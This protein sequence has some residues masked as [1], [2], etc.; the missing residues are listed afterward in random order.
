MKLSVIT[1]TIRKEGLEIVRKSLAKQT[2]RDF[3]W[4]VCAPFDPEIP[5]ARFIVDNFGDGYWTL[6]RCYNKLFRASKGEL[7]VSYQD[8]IWT[9][10]DALEKFWEMYKETGGSITSVGD[11]YDQ[12]DEYGRPTNA[13]WFD[14][15][16]R[17]DTLGFYECNWEDC[18]WNF[19]ATPREAIFRIGGAD[20]KLDF[21]GFGGDQFQICERLNEIG[22]RFYIDQNNET[23]TL[24]HGRER[25][26]WD[27]D[28]V[29]R[30]GAYERRK[31]ELR[32]TGK[33]PVLDFLKG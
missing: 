4:L 28:H 15:R 6:N 18:E 26:N 9:Y 19:S 2:F 3:E 32:E 14:P 21:L 29:L 17:K 31:Q 5:E 11:Q 25:E 16:K 8:Y 30:N 12:L 20:E 10:P 27:R 13:V 1:P 23:R 33:W 7:I 24:R 22:H